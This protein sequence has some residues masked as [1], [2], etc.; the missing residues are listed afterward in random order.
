MSMIAGTTIKKVGELFPSDLQIRDSISLHLYVQTIKF[1]ELNCDKW[2]S[3]IIWLKEMKDVEFYDFVL[4]L[5]IMK[6]E[7]LLIKIIKRE[8]ID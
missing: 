5:L 1:N 2:L 8:S 7:D 3:L 4:G 6:D